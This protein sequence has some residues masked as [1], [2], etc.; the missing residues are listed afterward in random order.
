MVVARFPLLII[1]LLLLGRSD[2]GVSFFFNVISAKVTIMVGY[3]KPKAVGCLRASIIFFRN[4]AHREMSM[5]FW[6]NRQAS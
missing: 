3:D 1:M 5:F 6:G 4:A 2:A